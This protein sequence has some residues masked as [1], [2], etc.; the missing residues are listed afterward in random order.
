[1]CRCAIQATSG[2]LGPVQQCW[3]GVSEESG[4]NKVQTGRVVSS[5]SGRQSAQGRLAQGTSVGAGGGI[6]DKK[7]AVGECKDGGVQ[8]RWGQ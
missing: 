8:L 7:E 3:K 6:C 5:Q 1:M 2:Q 4:C